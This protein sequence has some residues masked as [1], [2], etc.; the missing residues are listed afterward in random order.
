MRESVDLTKES[1]QTWLLNYAWL[2]TAEERVREVECIMSQ[3]DWE[4]IDARAEQL[5]S[6]A[7]GEETDLV[8]EATGFALSALYECH[9]APHLSTCPRAP[10]VPIDSVV[11]HDGTQCKVI[12]RRPDGGYLLRVLGSNETKIVPRSELPV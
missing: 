6:Q 4:F 10:A 2:G 12:G 9:D 1:I 8:G 11:E 5:M 7:S 3:D